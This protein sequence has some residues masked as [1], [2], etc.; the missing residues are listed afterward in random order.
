MMKLQLILISLL[1]LSLSGMERE[2]VK[3]LMAG[4][5][6]M[7]DKPLFK[8]GSDT[9][10][11]EL[12][13]EVNR[14]RGWGQL[15]PELIS[16]KGQVISYARNGRSTR[17]FIEEGLWTELIENSSPG[18]IVVIQFGHNDEVITKKSYTNPVQ[19]RLNFVAFV[20][21]VKARGA[22]PVLCTSVARRKF[23]E[24]GKLVPTHGDYPDIIRSV[25]RQENVP[26]IDLEKITSAWLQQAGVEG[27]KAFFH[28]LPPGVSRLHPGGLNDNTHFNEEGA[29]AVATFFIQEIKK[30]QMNELICLI[31]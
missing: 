31:K 8:S 16:D 24:N 18:D 30:Q 14:E 28:H 13:E 29:R 1:I 15:L 10:T 6:T 4:D 9:I 17:T 26:L 27:S 25:A 3:I 22:H 21:E 20:N 7:A 11:G 12:F 23:D 19:F 5:S 2:Q